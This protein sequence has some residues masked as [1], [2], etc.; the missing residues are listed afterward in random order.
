MSTL[1]IVGKEYYLKHIFGDAFRFYIPRYQRPYAWTTEET[2]DLLDDLW[3]AHTSEDLPVPK[4][5]PYFLGSVVLIKEEH[6]PQSE[7]IDGQQRLTTLTILISVLRHLQPNGADALSDYLRQKGKFYEGMKDEYRL[8]LRPQDAE[9]FEKHIQHEKGLSKIE[10]LNPSGLRNDAQRNIRANALHLINRLQNR[11]SEELATFTQFIVT[12]CLLVAVSTPD[13]DSAYRIFSVMNDRGL[14]LSHSDILKAE[15]IGKI[16]S[17]G[18]Q[19]SYAQKWET[20][21]ENLGR[22]SFDDLFSHIRMIAAKQKLRTTTLKEIREFVKPGADPINFIDHQLTPYA[23]AFGTIKTAHYKSAEGAEKINN[24]LRWLNRLDNSDWVPPALVA[25]AKHGNDPG[26]LGDFFA[27]LERVAACMTI[28]RYSINDR[29]DRYAEILQAL[30]AP[31]A[32]TALAAKLELT[33]AE[34]HKTLNNL[35]GNLYELTKV[36]AYV[37]LRLDTALSGGGAAYD[38]PIITIEHVLPQ[39]PK[40]P[41][42]WLEWFP[43]ESVREGWLHRL[44]NL[45]L[46]PR[47]KNS[48]AQNFDFDTKK[49]KY[50]K[51]DKGVSTFALTSQVLGESEWTQAVLQSRQQNL[52]EKLKTLWSLEGGDTV[53]EDHGE[54][55]A[56][57]TQVPD[58]IARVPERYDIRKKFWTGLL[59][60]A[61][62][63]TKLHAN[64]SPR[65][66][67]WLGGATGKRGLGLNYAVTEHTTRVE[68]YIDRRGTQAEN[69]ATFDELHARKA[70][71][72]TAFGEGLDWQRMNEHR[73]CT[74]GHTIKLGGWRDPAEWPKVYEVTS[75]A[76]VRLEKALKPAIATLQI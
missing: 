34:K 4:K 55:S 2:G 46:L 27:Q 39:N 8:T 20:A 30:E 22:A 35:D 67:Y 5:D 76:M 74:I 38:Y 73:A 59:E 50:F 25:L 72:D 36:R 7:V 31:D 26:W 1:Q 53:S 44:A 75:D 45:L 66:S 21:E 28:M 13:M 3:T 18:D 54:E 68:L 51:S 37:L 14:D 15:V 71:I 9:F 65:P 48:E 16:P 56:A 47:K 57:E 61:K 58:P 23:D 11:T 17:E 29:M 63:K 49:E 52:L 62:A 40:K 10:G 6:Q 70:E 12:K 64:R 43:E 19:D 60:V 24:Y 33:Q 42:K 69:K 41:S 32:E